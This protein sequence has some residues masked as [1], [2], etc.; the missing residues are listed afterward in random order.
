MWW[1]W[2]SPSWLMVMVVAVTAVV[3][4]AVGMVVRVAV[5][6][7]VLFQPQIEYPGVRTKESREERS[8]LPLCVPPSL[9]W[10]V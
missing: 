10:K 5:V 9:S 7:T 8:P 6:V 4:V 3:I 1:Q 2:W